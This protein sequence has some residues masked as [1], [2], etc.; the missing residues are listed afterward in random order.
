M[1]FGG[2]FAKLLRRDVVGGSCCCVESRCPRPRRQNHVVHGFFTGCAFGLDGRSSTGASRTSTASSSSSGR[3]TPPSSPSWKMI[4]PAKCS[5]PRLLFGANRGGDTHRRN[6]KLSTVSRLLSKS[7]KR[8][9]VNS[10]YT[11]TS[12]TSVWRLVCVCVCVCHR[13]RG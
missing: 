5:P 2:F 13:I 3:R 8:P 11:P 12:S 4:T 6:I 9:N 1:H 10:T 7:Y